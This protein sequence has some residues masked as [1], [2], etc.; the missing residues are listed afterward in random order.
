MLIGVLSDTHIPA[1]AS[2]VPEQV[3][4]GFAGVNLIL[5]AGDLTSYA[6]VEQLEELA[7]VKAVTGNMDR[8]MVAQEFPLEL[9]LTI[10]GVKIAIWHG[11]GDFA[12]QN[13]MYHSLERFPAANCIIFGHT[14]QPF[15][16]YI[17][18]T[19]LLNPGSPTDK[20]WQ[21]EYSFALLEVKDGQINR[22]ELKYFS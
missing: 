12:R 22:A 21:Q 5:H 13:I 18:N 19:L 14:H 17:N 16:E 9:V 2:R 1:A 20:R 10:A 3:I 8:K 7:P 6:V 15:K 11:H 4:A